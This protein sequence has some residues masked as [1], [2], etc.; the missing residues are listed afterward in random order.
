MRNRQ[1]R[2]LANHIFSLP[3][4]KRISFIQVRLLLPDGKTTE[5]SFERTLIP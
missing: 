2:R 4:W 1:I 3:E 5:A